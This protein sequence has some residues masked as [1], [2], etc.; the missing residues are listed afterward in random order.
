MYVRRLLFLI[1][2]TVAFSVGRKDFVGSKNVVVDLIALRD[3]FAVIKYTRLQRTVPIMSGA[4]NREVLMLES[5][6]N[7]A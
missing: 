5:S 1:Q 2:L 3:S 4:Y 7:R 6:F